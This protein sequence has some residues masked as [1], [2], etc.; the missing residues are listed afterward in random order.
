MSNHTEPGVSTPNFDTGVPPE[1]RARRNNSTLS[2]GKQSPGA[3]EPPTHSSARRGLGFLALGSDDRDATLRK[4]FGQL[5][6]SLVTDARNRQQFLA[7]PCQHVA[8]G[9]DPGLGE[10][11]RPPSGHAQF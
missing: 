4:P 10:L 7:A 11:V 3:K 5:V 8:D 6:D 1:L 9:S 2:I